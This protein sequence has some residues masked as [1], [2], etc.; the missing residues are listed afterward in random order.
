M[1]WPYKEE[2]KNFS[3]RLG[4]GLW[5]G[6]GFYT[7]NTIVARALRL[8]RARA[9]VSCIQGKGQSRAFV[10]ILICPSEPSRAGVKVIHVIVE[11]KEINQVHAH[12]A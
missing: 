5:L 6:K 1:T 3:I 4:F 10:R 7:R 8:V 11:C 12:L 9:K 2:G